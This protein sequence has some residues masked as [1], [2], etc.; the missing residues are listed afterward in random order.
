[1]VK[2]Q[3]FGRSSLDSYATYD[4]ATS[5]L[6]THRKLPRA[7]LTE[8]FVTLPR[9]GMMRSG[10]VFQQQRLVRSTLGRGS[11]LLPT[12]LARDWMDRGARMNYSTRRNGRDGGPTLAS[13][14]GGPSNPDFREWLMGFPIGWTQ[15]G[16]T[17]FEQRATLSFLR[18]LNGSLSRL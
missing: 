9:A 5:S 10:T 18:L 15:T 1:M 16:T 6:K 3:V 8:S 11:G 4:P 7:V 2:G 14:L 13:A 17:E 12:P